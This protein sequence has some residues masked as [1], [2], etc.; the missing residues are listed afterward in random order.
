MQYIKSLRLGV[1]HHESR[2]RQSDRITDFAFA[3]AGAHNIKSP[4]R[5][6]L[7]QSGVLLTRPDSETRGSRIHAPVVQ[8][9][10]ALFIAQT[11]TGWSESAASGT[12]SIGLQFVERTHSGR[13]GL[14]GL[15]DDLRRAQDVTGAGRQTSAARLSLKLCVSY[16]KT[17]L[18]NRTTWSD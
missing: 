8:G 12:S 11:A 17:I 3:S 6:T 15:V 14:S 1:F 5:C 7:A 4:G 10:C 16:G 18:Q 2:S 9:V 13:G